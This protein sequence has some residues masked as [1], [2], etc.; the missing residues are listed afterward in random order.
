MRCLNSASVRPQSS[1]VL[2]GELSPAMIV[3]CSTFT[4]AAFATNSRTALFALPFSGGAVT[5]TFKESPNHPTMPELEAD[6][7]TLSFTLI[8]FDVT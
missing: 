1:I 4:P 8:L 5:L 6:G 2:L 7:T 3:V